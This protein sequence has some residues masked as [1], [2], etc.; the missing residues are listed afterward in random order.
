LSERTGRRDAEERV[1]GVILA[2][3]R[4]TRM[5]GGSKLLREFGASTVIHRVVSTAVSA[6]LDPVIVTLRHDEI[7]VEEALTDLDIRI[8]RVPESPAGRRISAFAG[9]AALADEDEPVVAA[10]I[11]L[12]DE[13]G[14]GLDDVRTMRSAWEANE[15]SA[16]RPR[17][18]DR[19][20][21]PVVLSRDALE[22][23]SHFDRALDPEIGLWDLVIRSG[24]P[25]MEVPIDRLSPVDVDTPS[26]LALAREE[27]RH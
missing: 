24:I 10:M 19:S 11:L 20:G 12:G 7:G 26:D 9:I 4:S 16:L 23:I 5:P 14:L 13:P 17:F 18:R 15:S 25:H 3:G 27:Q 22:V 6:G 2:A 8:A 21:H 1:A